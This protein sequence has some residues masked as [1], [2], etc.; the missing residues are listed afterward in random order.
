MTLINLLITCKWIQLFDWIIQPD[1]L[2]VILVDGKVQFLWNIGGS[3]KKLTHSM[4][5]Q[6]S[7]S[8]K[9]HWYQVTAER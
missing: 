3:T 5:I 8:T 1:F 4:K 9:D 7:S 2:A 6:A